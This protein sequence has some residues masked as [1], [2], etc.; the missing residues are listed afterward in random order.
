MAGPSRLNSSIRRALEAAERAA[1]TNRPGTGRGNRGDTP[2]LAERDRTAAA[3]R[4]RSRS[5]AESARTTQ[6]TSSINRNRAVSAED[7]RQ[8]ET[9]ADIRTMQRR[10]DEMPEGLRRRTMQRMLDAQ[11][12]SLDRTR[13]AEADRA[14]RRS[15]QAARDRNAPPVTLPEMP[16]SKG[17][18][19][20]KKYSKG[21][22]ARKG[23]AKGGYA[24]C[25]ASVPA[26]GKR[27]K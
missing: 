12:E 19:A 1:R 9:A 17:G 5:D 6:R 24:N 21:G 27:R 2:E 16:F 4:V 18:M 20:K 22:M 14:S 13:A 10:I 15:A 7:I 25:G 3:E 26:D 11:Q 23:Y 8:A